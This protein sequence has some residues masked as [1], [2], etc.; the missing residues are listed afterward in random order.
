MAFCIGIP[1]DAASWVSDRRLDLLIPVQLPYYY[2][3]GHP[4]HSLPHGRTKKKMIQK[5]VLLTLVTNKVNVVSDDVIL[6]N[7]IV[8]TQ[9]VG[10][11]PRMDLQINP[12]Q[13]VIYRITW[14]ET[15]LLDI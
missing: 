14:G 15:G 10:A 7:P 3:R 2:T 9:Y 4:T 13:T 1:T 12:I 8:Q 6:R 11:R 5:L